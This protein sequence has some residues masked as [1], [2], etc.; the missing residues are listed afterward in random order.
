MNQ[1]KIANDKT[2]IPTSLNDKLTLKVP[3]NDENTRT[4]M[5]EPIVP[6]VPLTPI[7]TPLSFSLVPFAIRSSTIGKYSSDERP[8]RTEK[9]MSHNRDSIIDMNIMETPVPII[10]IVRTVKSSARPRAL[11]TPNLITVAAPDL[12]D[13]NKPI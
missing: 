11:F 9:I 1:M 8:Q 7:A 6:T 5:A 10:P 12:S 3:T 2:K 13:C 4:P